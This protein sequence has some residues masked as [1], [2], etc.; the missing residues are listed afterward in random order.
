[1]TKQNPDARARLSGPRSRWTPE[2]DEILARVYPNHS[3]AET[4]KMLPRHG[5]NSIRQRASRLGIYRDPDLLYAERTGRF[6]LIRTMPKRQTD[7]KW[8]PPGPRYP[9]VWAMA[10]GVTA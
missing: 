6:R 4:E 3:V 8:Q 7:S 5:G 9:S 10:Q 2:E 1:M